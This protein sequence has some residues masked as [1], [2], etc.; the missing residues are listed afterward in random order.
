MHVHASRGRVRVMPF[1]SAQVADGARRAVTAG[2]WPNGYFSLAT[3]VAHL[4]PG[5]WVGADR[6]VLRLCG[7]LFGPLDP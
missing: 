2:R 5:G 3:C 4:V 7:R 6:A 1:R